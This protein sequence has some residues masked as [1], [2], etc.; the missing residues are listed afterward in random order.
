MEID[1]SEVTELLPCSGGVP[2][3]YFFFE[4]TT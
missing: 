1:G 3:L 4:V 2:Y